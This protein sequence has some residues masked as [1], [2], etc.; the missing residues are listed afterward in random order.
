M[1][2]GQSGEVH[3]ATAEELSLKLAEK[4]AQKCFTGVELYSFKDN[5]RSLADSNNSGSGFLYWNEDTLIRFLSIPDCLQVGSIIFQSAS[6][7]GAFPFPSLSPAILNFEA[8]IKVV[9]IYTGRYKKVLK[10]HPDLVKLLFRSLAVYD[11]SEDNE[12]KKVDSPETEFDYYDDDDD[13]L[14]LAALDALDAIEVFGQAE[15]SNINHA[16]IPLENLRN[17][18]AFLLVIAPLE[19]NQPIAVFAERF[20]T[21]EALRELKDTAECVVKSFRSSD[22]KGILYRDFKKTV[23]D[24]VP[25]LFDS[26]S[27]LYEH[28]L[29]S[30][31]VDNS[32]TTLGEP[33][34]LL[35]YPG[36]ILDM[37]LLC[38]LSLFIKGDNL[39]RRL[40]PLY[41]GS[42]AGFSMGSFETKVVK[43]TAPTIL[44]VSGTRIA[45]VPETHQQRMFCDT[46]PPRK[47]AAGGEVDERV[48][49]GVYMHN[50]WR[51]SHRDCF[52]DSR[53]IL[54]QLEPIHRTFHA[55]TASTDYAYFNKDDG[56]GFGSPVQKMKA[57]QR[58]PYLNLGP[59]S[60]TFDP[61]LEFGVFQHI[62][63]GG[64]FHASGTGDEEWQDLFE[65]EEIEVWGCGGDSEAEAQRKAWAWEEREALLRRQINIGKDIEADR[66][67]LEMAGLIGQNRSGGST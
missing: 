36:K 32:T 57:S 12:G 16:R 23:K 6:Y 20:S 59:V 46:L 7:L 60:L 67:L 8:L 21:A 10:H 38:Q 51:V 33:E 3:T 47:Y 40:R 63:H 65:I 44:L 42:E 56:I 13:D 15:K 53:S 19:P 31:K 11:R 27:P 4:F 39:W 25:F 52:G 61:S 17:L 28:L 37:N 30:K 48:V 22:G 35:L 18:I 26:L 62:G 9:T 55:S 34:P 5:F 54:F 50:P 49:Y 2:Q 45:R 64:A 41:A 58:S 43:W 24:S 66:A 29:F 1:G 14:S